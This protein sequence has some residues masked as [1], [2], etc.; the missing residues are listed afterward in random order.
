M[1]NSMKTWSENRLL[2]YHDSFNKGTLGLMENI[3]PLVFSAT[4]ILEEDVLAYTVTDIEKYDTGNK[5]DYYIRSSLSN[6]FAKVIQNF[7]SYS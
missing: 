3:L 6:A 4:K 1:L 7:I 2:D 5:V